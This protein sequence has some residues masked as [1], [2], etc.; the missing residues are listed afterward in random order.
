MYLN[1][2]LPTWP[3]IAVKVKDDHN[4]A[5]QTQGKNHP[6]DFRF[7]HPE[8]VERTEQ[9][10]QVLPAFMRP[11]AASPFD[12][13]A[14]SE[15]LYHGEEHRSGSLTFAAPYLLTVHP[16]MSS[17]EVS[18]VKM[19]KNVVWGGLRGERR[20]ADPRWSAVS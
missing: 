12:G 16:R 4:E 2:F 6:N 7:P 18:V 20:S 17:L 15:L 13:A 19:E 5:S 8:S 9:Q 3:Q 1:E 11:E 14:V 10:S